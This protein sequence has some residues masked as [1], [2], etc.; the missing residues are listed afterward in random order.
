MKDDANPEL[1]PLIG[2]LTRPAMML[3]IPYALFVSELAL[4][5]VIFV[6]AKNLLMLLLGIPVHAL[7]YWLTVRDVRFMDV[8]ATRFSKCPPTW[9]RSFWGGVSYGP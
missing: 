8:I 6:L 7:S 2:G 1:D 4:V 9:N 3:G 5:I